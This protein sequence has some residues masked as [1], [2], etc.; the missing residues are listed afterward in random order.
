MQ[1][2]R[3]KLNVSRDVDVDGYGDDVGYI[4]NLPDG[5]RFYDEVVH[6]RGFDSMRELRAAAKD[7]VIP[8][9]CNGCI[10]A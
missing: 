7:T 4:L 6:V 8:C 10:K 9:D 1:A 5:F 3:Y 2:K